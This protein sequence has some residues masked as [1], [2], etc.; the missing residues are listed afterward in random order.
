MENVAE[1]GYNYFIPELGD[2]V[3]TDLFESLLKLCLAVILLLLLDLPQFLLELLD[4]GHLDLLLGIILL[5][6]LSL[7]LKHFPLP[8]LLRLA[9]S[10]VLR[11][12]DL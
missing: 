4:I 1:N 12:W 9:L 6:H 5:L 2:G 8:C 3:D 7:I 10:R 11:L